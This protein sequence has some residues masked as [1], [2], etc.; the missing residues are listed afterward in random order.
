[1]LAPV[2]IHLICPKHPLRSQ[3][4]PFFADLVQI[5]P[6]GLKSVFDLYLLEEGQLT[7]M[8]FLDQ[9]HSPFCSIEGAHTFKDPQ[10]GLQG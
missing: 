10:V 8:M 1:M 9:L 2:Y 3:K 4:D 5:L 6:I 7:P